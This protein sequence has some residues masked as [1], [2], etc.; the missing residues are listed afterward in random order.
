MPYIAL[1]YYPLMPYIGV[2]HHYQLMPYINFLNHYQ[3]PYDVT[4]H[5]KTYQLLSATC[6]SFRTSFFWLSFFNDDFLQTLDQTKTIRGFVSS[7]ECVFTN[8]NN[9]NSILYIINS[10]L[11]W[12]TCSWRQLVGFDVMGLISMLIHLYVYTVVTTKS[13]IEM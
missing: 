7:L 5:I 2:L 6:F 3:M 8:A 11:K 13:A 9:T 10:I 1:S 4:H 12:E